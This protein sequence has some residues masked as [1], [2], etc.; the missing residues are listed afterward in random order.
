MTTFEASCTSDIVP[1]H[2]FTHTLK[3]PIQYFP[4]THLRNLPFL[5]K[6]HHLH[7]LLHPNHNPPTTFPFTIN[8][9]YLIKYFQPPTSP[10]HQPIQPPLKLPK[11]PYPLPFIIPP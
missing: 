1:I 7:H 3:R 2:H 6:F 10:L 9:H 4:H 11:A 8:P 5:T